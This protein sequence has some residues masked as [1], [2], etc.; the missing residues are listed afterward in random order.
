VTS[1]EAAK[2]PAGES[3]TWLG[4]DELGTLLGVS[5]KTVERWVYRYKDS[6]PVPKPNHATLMLWSPEQVPEWR[7]W[8]QGL[9]GRGKGGG[10]PWR[11]SPEE[12]AGRE[13]T[14]ALRWARDGQLRL[15]R[16]VVQAAEAGLAEAELV[17]LSETDVETV[18]QWL[19][20]EKPPAKA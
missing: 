2:T 6:H 11:L 19:A 18:R 9:P 3:P 8:R 10:R 13:I 4:Y 7:V 1:S 15:Q 16:T 5:G 12:R 17:R 20:A 14:N